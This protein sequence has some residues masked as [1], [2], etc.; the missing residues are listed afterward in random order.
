MSWPKTV[1]TALVII[2][3]IVAVA[4]CAAAFAIFVQIVRQGGW[5]LAEPSVIESRW[6]MV[7]LWML[8]GA[9]I[10]LLT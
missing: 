1:E 10:G 8:V 4:G 5:K 9:V 6:R 7:R 3:A 2:F